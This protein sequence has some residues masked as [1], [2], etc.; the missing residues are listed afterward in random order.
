MRQTLLFLCLL[1]LW[2]AAQT[3]L[4]VHPDPFEGS[5]QV[6]LS[7]HWAEPIAHA[8]VINKSDQALGIRW[9]FELQSAPQAWEY[10]ICDK[11][12]CYS[13][14]VLSNVNLDTGAPNKPVDLAPGDSSLLDLHILPRGQAG[15]GVF[16][17][18]L[19]TMDAP[20]EYI[21]TALY[22]VRIDGLTA[23]FEREAPRIQVWPNPA[24]A[25]F[26][27]S[28]NAIVAHVYVYNLLGRQMAS[29]SYG[30][31]RRYDI[32]AL[33][34]GMYFVALVGKKG[35]VWRTIRLTKRAARP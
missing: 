28:E 26:T 1:P 29:F 18:Y 16:H 35:E 33:P 2:S 4:E 23:T 15:E 5:F 14:G 10:R 13:T 8:V 12:Q 25:W 27:L 11:N 22:Y 31:G 7:D 24:D 6:D 21:D 30:H 20:T 19:A 3:P 34:P 9:V 32:S 17:I